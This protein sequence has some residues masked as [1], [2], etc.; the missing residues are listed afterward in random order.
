MRT[1]VIDPDRV[2]AA[3]LGQ[4]L[5][6]LGCQVDVAST[7]SEAIAFLKERRFDVIL[8]DVRW[9][10]STALVIL[11]EVYSDVF[12]HLDSPRIRLM[13][14]SPASSLLAQAQSSGDLKSIPATA[15]SILSFV[16]STDDSNGV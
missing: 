1:L 5:K 2:Y 6:G 15:E 13:S 9:L 4:V 10:S 12:R 11:K 14:N 7:T 3:T 8:M 16:R